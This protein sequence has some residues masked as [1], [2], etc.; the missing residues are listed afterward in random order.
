MSGSLLLLPWLALPAPVSQ[1]THNFASQPA[2][3]AAPAVSQPCT[4]RR[5]GDE[6]WAQGVSPPVA[7]PPADAPRPTLVT[8]AQPEKPVG[9]PEP[10]EERP[11][12][13]VDRPDVSESSYTVPKGMVQAELG[14]RFTQERG[15]PALYS[16]DD[17]FRIGFERNWEL[18]VGGATPAY[19]DGRTHGHVGILPF[20]LGLKRHFSD[21][22]GMRPSMGWLLNV[23][24]PSPSRRFTTG[25]VDADVLFVSNSSFG[26][27]EFE[28]NLGPGIGRDADAGRH[29]P[30]AVYA[31]TPSYYPMESLRIYTEVFGELPGADN[32]RNLVSVG[33][34]VQWYDLRRLIAIDLSVSTGLS[35]LARDSN[36][37]SI[38]LGFTILR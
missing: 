1:H 32:G 35:R 15:D 9:E 33:G 38:S 34:G 8:R 19:R 24:L 7:S 25:H 2:L 23:N 29:F 4:P 3:H 37:M 12:F 30:Q 14:L 26:G 10:A 13:V 28:V 36:Q 21:E 11:L 5:R 18:R 6:P 27:W 16:I 31:F 20:Y 22:K 17:L